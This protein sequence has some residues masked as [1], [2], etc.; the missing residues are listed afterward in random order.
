MA[1][2]E[3]AGEKNSGVAL[4]GNWTGNWG[5]FPRRKPDGKCPHHPAQLPG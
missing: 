3:G 1:G 4:A 2:G 5:H